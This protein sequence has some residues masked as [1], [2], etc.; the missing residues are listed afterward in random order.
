MAE[1]AVHVSEQLAAACLRVLLDIGMDV[2]VM[3][4]MLGALRRRLVLAV[5]RSQSPGQLERQQHSNEDCDQVL[6]LGRIITAASP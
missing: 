4:E 3:T 2:R 5:A 1:A 6:H